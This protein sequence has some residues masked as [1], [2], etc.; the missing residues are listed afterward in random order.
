MTFLA[1][2]IS[3]SMSSIDI[4]SNPA[5]TEDPDSERLD[6]FTLELPQG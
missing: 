1:A 2:R 4:Q 6:S 5:S 3:T